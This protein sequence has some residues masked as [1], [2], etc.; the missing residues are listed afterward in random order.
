MTYEIEDSSECTVLPYLNECTD[1]VM[2]NEFDKILK[3]GN[4]T[5]K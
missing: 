4:F 5:S 3:Y 2:T 1:V